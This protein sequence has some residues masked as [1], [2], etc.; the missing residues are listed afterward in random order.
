MKITVIKRI[1]VFVIL[2]SFF[3]V[4]AQKQRDYFIVKPPQT[5]SLAV[6]K[7]GMNAPFGTQFGFSYNFSPK[8]TLGIGGGAIMN[9]MYSYGH[10]VFV[11]NL[12][13]ETFFDETT[14]T[15][16]TLL[17]NAQY[18]FDR[19]YL[20]MEYE[21]LSMNPQTYVTEDHVFDQMTYASV[22]PEDTLNVDGKVP[23]FSSHS[24]LG[25]YEGI[26]LF[27]MS[28]RFFVSAEGGVK[29][30]VRS[31]YAFTLTNDIFDAYTDD[32]QSF[33]NRVEENIQGYFNEATLIPMLNIFLVYKLKT[34]DC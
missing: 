8:L 10:S 27:N 34:C 28:P 5:D 30:K 1:F 21:L 11:S 25:V 9:S 29:F 24:Y 4:N 7:V 6:F 14:W 19:S 31:R 33:L 18:A 20:K 17:L 16:R 2:L 23:L 15:G 22:F 32:Q 12:E 26:V 3:S 13:T